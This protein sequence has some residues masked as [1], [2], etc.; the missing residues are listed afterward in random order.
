MRLQAWIV[1]AVLVPT[2]ATAQ[3][4]ALAPG[5]RVR[6][7]APQLFPGRAIGSIMSVDSDSARIAVPV[8]GVRP[9]TPEAVRYYWIRPSTNRVEVSQG[10]SRF[11]A[12][13]RG[14]W[15]GLAAGALVAT[16]VGIHESTDIDR[17][18]TDGEEMMVIILPLFAA[19][20]GVIGGALGAFFTIERWRPLR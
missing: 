6:V 3:H 15:V 16:I 19:S 13:R 9:D 14:A 2:T 1:A 17:G 5:A 11:G 4:S 18:G 20:T 7:Q 12:M 10:R 8:H